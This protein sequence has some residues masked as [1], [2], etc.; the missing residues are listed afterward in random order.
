MSHL[1]PLSAAE[2][3]DVWERGSALDATRRALLLLAAASPGTAYDEIAQLSIGARNARLL[4]LRAQLLGE[5]LIAVTNCQQCNE[6]LEIELHT[7]ELGGEMLPPPA[8]LDVRVDG[9]SLRVRVPN[10]ADL[11]AVEHEAPLT[12]AREKL[13]E[14][15]LVEIHSAHDARVREPLPAFVVDAVAEKMA[16]ADPQADLELALT[17]PHCGHAWQTPLDPVAFLWSEVDAWAQRILREVHTLASAY[18]WSEGE[19]L[20]LSPTRRLRYLEMIY[21]EP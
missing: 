8:P 19:I 6:R 17:C 7:S 13:L 11:L 21:G 10:S 18:K 2:L 4:A 12:A 3:L 16:Q 20:A 15:C 9:Y 5:T 14:R 1:T